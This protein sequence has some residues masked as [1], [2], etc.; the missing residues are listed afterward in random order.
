MPTEATARLGCTTL[1]CAA[2]ASD[3]TSAERVQP[4]AESRKSAAATEPR[5]ARAQITESGALRKLAA[6]RC[7]EVRL[8]EHRRAH[9]ICIELAGIRL[10]FAAIKVRAPRTPPQGLSGHSTAIVQPPRSQAGSAGRVE[11][12]MRARRAASRRRWRGAS[13]YSAARAGRRTVPGT[14]RAA[15]AWP[16]AQGRASTRTWHP[17]G[18]SSIHNRR[19]CCARACACSLHHTLPSLPVAS[20][21]RVTV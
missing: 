15:G 10:P 5:A 16:D 2:A 17:I 13:I 20:G 21:N 14:T 11:R 7:A 1:A 9:N 6:G 18:S 19:C 3:V 4:C 12:R 8:V